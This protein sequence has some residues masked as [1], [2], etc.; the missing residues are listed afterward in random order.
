MCDDSVSGVSSAATE[1]SLYT[2]TK[3]SFEKAVVN[4][5]VAI[6]SWI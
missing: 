3:F 6:K 2:L 5:K 1:T 4:F